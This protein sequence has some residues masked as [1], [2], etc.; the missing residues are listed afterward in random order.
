MNEGYKDFIDYTL[1]YFKEAISSKTL[2]EHLPY[3]LNLLRGEMN[4]RWSLYDELQEA[5]AEKNRLQSLI[6]KWN[7]FDNKLRDLIN[8]REELESEVGNII[9]AKGGEVWLES[10]IETDPKIIHDNMVPQDIKQG[11]RISVD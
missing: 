4:A 6:R 9:E 1:S 8:E 3:C 11:T 2:E 10:L 5:L 7:S